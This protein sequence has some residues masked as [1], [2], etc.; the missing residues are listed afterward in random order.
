MR[1]QK[2]TQLQI[3]RDRISGVKTTLLDHGLG[4]FELLIEALDEVTQEWFPL[5]IAPLKR[6]PILVSAKITKDF[7]TIIVTFSRL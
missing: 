1:N 2:A 7:F 6:E 5:D 3:P 4:G